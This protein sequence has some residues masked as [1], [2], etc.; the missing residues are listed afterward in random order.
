MRLLTVVMATGCVVGGGEQTYHF[1]DLAGVRIELGSG[2]VEV[3]GE[4]DRH[5]SE[6]TL[7]IGG[8]G[9]K[10]AR[11]ELLVGDD[12]WLTVDANG[13]FM[14]GGDI[15][16]WLPAGMPVEVFVERGDAT[17]F[18][19]RPADVVACVA[20]GSVTIEVPMGAYRLDL[21]GGAGAVS[22]QDV[23]GDDEAVHSIEACVGAGDVDV[24]GFDPSEADPF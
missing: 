7:D 16:A 1:D 6:I 24:I 20:A 19:E 4:E 23:W 14:G 5:G 13:G 22:T 2:D 18:L 10:N 15:E 21:N 8:V 17:V 11:G 12:G 3:F 9:K